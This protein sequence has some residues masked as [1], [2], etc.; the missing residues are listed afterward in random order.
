MNLEDHADTLASIFSLLIE[1][2]ER[3]EE[4]AA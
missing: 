1:I 3:E 4:E 2:A